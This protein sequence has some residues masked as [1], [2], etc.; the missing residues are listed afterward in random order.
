[1]CQSPDETGLVEIGVIGDEVLNGRTQ[2]Q[3]IVLRPSAYRVQ[4][5]EIGVGLSTMEKTVPG[6]SKMMSSKGDRRWGT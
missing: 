5:S 1:M 3:L 6:T 4:I 2:L